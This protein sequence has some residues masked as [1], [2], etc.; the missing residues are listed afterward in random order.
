MSS[1]RRTI[2]QRMDPVADLLL[3][4]HPVAYRVSFARVVGGAM[5]ALLLSQMYYW[6]NNK[7]ALG[8]ADN[9]F[10][11]TQ[12]EITEQTGLTRTETET[13]RRK[14]REAGVL[15]EEKRGL[16]MKIWFRINKNRL[17]EL[18]VQHARTCSATP[19]INLA[20]FPQD[21]FVDAA[22]NLAENLQDDLLDSRTPS[23][24][25]P[26]GL[27]VGKPGDITEI[28][29][30][31]PAKIHTEITTTSAPQET[32]FIR[33]ASEQDVVVS[34]ESRDTE[35][36]LCQPQSDCSDDKIVHLLEA[37][38]VSSRTAR[39]LVGEHPDRAKAQIAY[40][41]FRNVADRAATL[42]SAIKG[43]WSAPQGWTEAQQK[44][45]QK[46]RDRER[47]TQ[48]T[49][50]AQA[51]RRERERKTA[52]IETFWAALSDSERSEIERAVCDRVRKN[53]VLKMRMA[54]VERG[55]ACRGEALE[56]I[57]AGERRKVLLEMIGQ[58]PE[59]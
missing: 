19:P 46:N 2:V 9:S 48:A 47:V 58:K 34:A 35:Q 53:P 12:E 3:R 25:N 7:T 5:P 50:N 23:C 27:V 54:K 29:P 18:L 26:A 15:I 49:A 33:A 13:A 59:K 31:T 1:A 21:E 40:L 4:E 39:K 20:G 55:E 36:S 8:R 6:S 32:A 17:Y 57:L 38:G 30:E 14:L 42:V 45:K 10:Y 28:P 51:D 41:P 56:R 11:M 44:E 52:M 22:T 16:P 24:G 37:A 43:D